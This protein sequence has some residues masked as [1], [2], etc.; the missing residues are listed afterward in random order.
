MVKCGYLTCPK[1]AV[2]NIDGKCFFLNQVYAKKKNAFKVIAQYLHFWMITSHLLALTESWHSHPTSHDDNNRDR[3]VIKCL[4][5]QSE[6]PNDI[7]AFVMKNCLHSLVLRCLIKSSFFLRCQYLFILVGL[8][9]SIY[10]L[11]EKFPFIA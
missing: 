5:T 11:S 6:L 4:T 8:C 7:A 1:F 9:I 10:E 3:S 2:L